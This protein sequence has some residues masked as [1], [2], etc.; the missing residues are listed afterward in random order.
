M[1]G[2][3]LEMSQPRP[4]FG[5]PTIWLKPQRDLWAKS[6]PMDDR[7]A[8]APPHSVTFWEDRGHSSLKIAP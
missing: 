1:R 7:L 3:H 5:F 8:G 2:A 4:V 6:A